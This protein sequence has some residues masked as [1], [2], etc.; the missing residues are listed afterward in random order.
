MVEKQKISVRTKE[1]ITGKKDVQ[2]R[3]QEILGFIEVVEYVLLR[4]LLC[5][6]VTVA[7]Q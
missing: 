4:M 7:K 3:Y 5:F 6:L 1:Y 2:D